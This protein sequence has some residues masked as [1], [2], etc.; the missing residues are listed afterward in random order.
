MRIEPRLT[1]QLAQGVVELRT[2]PKELS[3]PSEVVLDVNS[4]CL[5]FGFS[6]E[7]EQVN[8]SPFVARDIWQ[9]FLELAQ[10]GSTT[11]DILN[12]ARKYGPLGLCLAHGFPSGHSFYQDGNYTKCDDM[13]FF[14]T[15]GP[16]V[17]RVESIDHWRVIAR[18]A[19]AI[20]LIADRLHARTSGDAAD[21]DVLRK[22]YAFYVRLWESRRGMFEPSTVRIERQSLALILNKW[23]ED[24]HLKPALTWAFD[25]QL[26]PALESSGETVFG[27]L[28]TQLLFAISLQSGLAFCANCSRRFKLRRGQS[29][30]SRVF[31]KRKNCGRKASE[32]FASRDNRRRNRLDPNREKKMNA[33]LT[34]QTKKKVKRE[35]AKIVGP[36]R[37]AILRLS[38]TYGVSVS[39]LYRVHQKKLWKEVGNENRK[40][41]AKR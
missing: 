4:Q 5:R 30:F 12:F 6:V 29:P 14:E 39:T 16:Q 23:I 18:E 41:K 31:C 15:V 19:E 36:L 37:P 7:S 27:V 26:S 11:E 20:V 32:R 28:T 38:Q 3:H 8:L 40:K 21:W 34:R 35:L 2:L 22:R 9:R 1:P 25:K 13:E 24:A 17:F 33:E 10:D